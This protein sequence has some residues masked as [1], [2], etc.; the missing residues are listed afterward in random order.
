MNAALKTLAQ[1]LQ[2]KESVDWDMPVS[3]VH[4]GNMPLVQNLAE[5][6]DCK[7]SQEVWFLGSVVGTHVGPGAVGITYFV[8]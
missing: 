7:D 5:L 8:K 2:E 1:M 6:L 3:Y 4:S